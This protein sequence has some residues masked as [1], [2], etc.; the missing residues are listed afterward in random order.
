MRATAETRSKLV[1][2]RARLMLAGYFGVVCVLMCSAVLAPVAG[3]PVAVFAGMG[4]ASAAE[5][6]A[7]AN[8]QLLAASQDGFVAVAQTGDAAGIEALYTAGAWL[9]TAAW[10]ASACATLGNG[11]SPGPR[12]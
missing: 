1:S 10:F 12:P 9:V 5:V 4:P 7:R 11:S 2:P 3:R 6:I 8:G